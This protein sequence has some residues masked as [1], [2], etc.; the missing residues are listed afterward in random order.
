MLKRMLPLLAL[1]PVLFI[2]G[3]ATSTFTSVTPEQ[4]PRNANNLYPVEFAFDSSQQSMRWDNIH[5]WVLVNGT[6]YPMRPVQ[7][8]QNRWEGLIPVPPNE[9]T[10][11][12]RFKFDYDRNV[13]GSSPKPDSQFSPLYMLKVVNQ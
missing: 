12:Y 13:F 10:V 5:T 4:V 11:V 9:D 6:I 1:V 8:V 3:C 7:G 2:A